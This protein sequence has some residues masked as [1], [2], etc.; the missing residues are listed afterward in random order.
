M[1]TT[2]WTPTAGEFPYAPANGTVMSAFVN[3][4][5]DIRWDDPS[6]LNTG[7]ATPSERASLTLTVTGIPTPR[8]A[9]TGTITVVSAP[10]PVG[11]NFTVQGVTFYSV[12]GS[13]G[14]NQF[15]GSSA[16]ASTVAA[17]IAAALNASTL[18]S[19]GVVSAVAVGAVVTVTAMTEGAAG[20][21]ITLGS[22]TPTLLLSS[23]TLTDGSDGAYLLLATEYLYAATTR[24]SG[25]RDFAV[26]ASPFDT[27]QSIA[28]AIN[29]KANNVGYVTASAYNA[30]VT[31]YASVEGSVGNGVYVATNEPTTLSLSSSTTSGGYGVPCAGK[32]NSRWSI[33]G[34]NVYRSDTGDR[35]P[36]FR[37][38]KV[39]VGGTFYRDRTDV[40]LVDNEVVDWSWGWVYKGDA[41][42]MNLWRL[43]TRYRTV[44][45]EAGNA[46]PANS[47][48]DVVVT[49][50]GRVAPVSRVLGQAGEIDLDTDP[51]WNPATET[52]VYPPLPK[53]DGTS[54]VTVTY[55]YARQQVV[56]ALDANSKIFYRLTTVAVDPTGT[57][58][59]GL[60]ETP[61][62]YS[63]P[64]PALDSEKTDYIWTEAVR[65]NRW[66]LE[67]GGER[68]KLFIRRVTGVP[69]PCQWDVAVFAFAKQPY[70]FC[71]CCY[72][73]GFLGGY[74]GPIDIIVAPDESER[75]V[76]QTPMGRRLENTYEVWTGPRPMLS[77]RDFI[78]KQ[79]GERFSVGPVRRT[80]VR[81]LTLQQA[82]TI[83]NLDEKDI[84]YC[85]PL[86]GLETLPWPQ[87]RYTRPQDVYERPESP[88]AEGDPFPVGFDYQATPMGSDV[89]R[90]PEG[91][92]LRGRTPVWANIMYGGKGPS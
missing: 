49:V 48:A 3:G 62:G 30:T 11:A 84:R 19:S 13:P 71:S 59:S 85:V 69:C 25:K 21:S 87:T 47:P 42:N 75:R 8:A 63:E 41:P 16:S 36:F 10:V 33:V 17:S 56:T 14:A 31:I 76:T 57:S 81:G 54:I 88:C 15:D 2:G 45:K 32:S 83:G 28:A 74:E 27:A 55:R 53:T 39:P 77:Q 60:V 86:V 90:I 23:G 6:T 92:Q 7:P 52:Y 80:Q 1:T 18:Y 46:V 4:T 89:P 37:V 91:R 38:N 12:A 78:V 67:Q 82:F 70:N 68:V 35:G 58:P 34:V 9:A 43:R 50:D 24:T 72:G 73:T 22:A 51:V 65:R 44:V 40:V 64:L 20:N 66:I 79:N 26:S 5:Y 61:L 29:D